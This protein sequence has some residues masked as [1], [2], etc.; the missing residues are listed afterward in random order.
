M[1]LDD[2]T[3]ESVYDYGLFLLNQILQDSGRSLAE[4]PSMPQFRE[5]WEVLALNPLIAEQLN[6]EPAALLADLNVRLQQMNPLSIRS[7]HRLCRDLAGK[8][9]LSEWTWWQREDFRI[10]HCLC[11]ASRHLEDCALCLLWNISSAHQRWL[12]G[13]FYVQD[14]NQWPS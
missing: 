4:L 8:A 10:Q 14:P 7:D 1:G 13:A 2:A 5:D 3:L 6:Y 9:F 11:E 12:H